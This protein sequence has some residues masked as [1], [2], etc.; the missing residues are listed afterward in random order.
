MFPAKAPTTQQTGSFVK[1]KNNNNNNPEMQGRNFFLTESIKAQEIML[2]LREET[3]SSSMRKGLPLEC[4]GK[5][6]SVFL[7]CLQETE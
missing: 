2:F 4:D 6:S 1:K 3:I 5:P 7:S